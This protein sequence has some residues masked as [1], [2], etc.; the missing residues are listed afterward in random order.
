MVEICQSLIQ[1]ALQA[2]EDKDNH[3]LAIEAIGLLSLLD[4]ELFN[5]YSRIFQTFL[6]DEAR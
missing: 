3:L 6:E 4:E 1:P 5:A 2:T